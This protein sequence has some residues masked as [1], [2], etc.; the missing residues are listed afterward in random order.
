M[1][2]TSF[3]TSFIEAMPAILS[4]IK[5]TLLASLYSIVIGTILG[6]LIGLVL[7]Y[8]NKILRAPFR[9][10]V[11]IIRGIP[12]LVTVFIMYYFLDYIMRNSFGISISAFT[13]GVVALALPCCAQTAELT[14]GAL[15]SISKG[16]TEAG[17]ALGMR[18]GRI[19][20][21]ILLP[22]TLL[23]MLP[24]WVN[25]ATEMVKGT[26]LLSMVGVVEL[27]LS[28]R[29]LVA[30]NLHAL[31]YYLVAGLIYFLINTLIETCGKAM[32]KKLDYHKK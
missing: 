26:T 20:V 17:R 25:T 32:E 22:Q 23:A 13:S 6:I 10:L 16:Q 1:N 7:N 9:L 24:P 3:F 2:Q 4:G 27:L 8:G 28:V 29:Q 11:D 31:Q 15:Q 12:P 5:N 19:F 21:K 14:R 30:V 18:F